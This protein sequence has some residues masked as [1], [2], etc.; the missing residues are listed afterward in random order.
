VGAAAELAKGA[1]SLAKNKAAQLAADFQERA[2]ETVG[3]QVAAT[4][5]ASL[6]QDAPTFEGNSLAA[7]DD[8]VAAFVNKTKGA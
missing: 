7:D 2:S 6:A 4:I 1:G 8:E 3:G 5:R